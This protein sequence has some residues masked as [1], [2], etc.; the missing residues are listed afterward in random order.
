MI[1]L[2]AFADDVL[3]TAAFSQEA[4]WV[5]VVGGPKTIKAIL[6]T[7]YSAPEGVGIVGVSDAAP[8]ALCKAS[9]VSDAK[10]GD[11]LSVGEV[12]YTVTEVMPHGDGFTTLRLS[13]E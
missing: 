12:D 4:V 7:E 6:D 10:R 1:D 13:R 9:D 11:S 8:V 3:D 2:S 5:P